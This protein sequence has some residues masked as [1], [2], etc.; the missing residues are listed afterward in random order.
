MGAK[1]FDLTVQGA[2]VHVITFGSGEKDLVMIQGLTL[3]EFS[4]AGSMLALGYRKFAKAYKVTLFDR[5]DPLPENC[6]IQDL[7]D[8]VAGAMDQLGIRNADIFG[9]SQG[10]MIALSLAIRRPDLVRKMVLAVT[11]A[12]ASDTTRT[13]LERWIGEVERGDQNA[14][15]IDFLES[16]Y[17]E[18]YQK[19]YR[20]LFPL[21]LK[22][23]K[24]I[25]NERFIALARSI[26]DFDVTGELSKISCPVLVLGGKED[27]VVTPE[28]S[29]EIAKALG[30]R[31]HMYDGLGHAAYE[32]APDFND[33]ILAF[34]QENA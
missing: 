27:K 28:G 5:P 7:T 3:R 13:V 33:R 9:T 20:R 4:G 34:L 8:S 1:E 30:C 32:E 11:A 10:G 6:G 17:S 22:T 19:R 31:I 21:I 24:L 18:H 29:S 16:M 14:L 25:S 12:K 26:K 2:N 15:A 23:Q